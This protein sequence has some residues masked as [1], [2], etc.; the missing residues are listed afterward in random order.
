MAKAIDLTRVAKKEL[1]MKEVTAPAADVGVIVGRFQV[2]EL[3]QAH[4][5][6][7]QYVM[8][9]HDRTFAA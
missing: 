1:D 3:H 7:I 6:L 9:R 4:R 5:E 8:D 2:H